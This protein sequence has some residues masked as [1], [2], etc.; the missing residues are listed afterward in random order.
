MSSAP[1]TSVADDVRATTDIRKIKE[2]LRLELPT[3]LTTFKRHHDVTTPTDLFNLY[4]NSALGE[5]EKIIADATPL[6][7]PTVNAFLNPKEVSIAQ[8]SYAQG[9]LD[10]LK[11]VQQMNKFIPTSTLL[12]SPGFVPTLINNLG[13]QA[14][15]EQT[16]LAKSPISPPSANQA[17]AVRPFAP[18]F[19]TWP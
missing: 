5:Y 13:A 6:S 17:E 9:F 10:T 1:S 18:T 4:K 19:F 7:T 12:N 2:T 3:N 8:Q 16:S 11:R 14:A 15:S